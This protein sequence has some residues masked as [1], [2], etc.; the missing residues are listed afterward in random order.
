M[1]HR[2][3]DGQYFMLKPCHAV[4]L[5]LALDDTDGGKR[6]RAL[7]MWFSDNVSVHRHATKDA[8]LLKA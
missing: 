1:Q 5:W 2:H 4:T 7:R 3:Q 8:W 6:M